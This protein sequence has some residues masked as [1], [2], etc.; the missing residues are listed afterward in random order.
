MS[1]RIPH[2]LLRAHR[3]FVSIPVRG[4]RSRCVSTRADRTGSQRLSQKHIYKSSI[5]WTTIAIYFAVGASTGVA[6]GLVQVINRASAHDRGRVEDIDVIEEHMA[7]QLP[8]GRPGTLTPDEEAR[9]RELWRLTLQVTGVIS[10]APSTRSNGDSP[11]P[12][13]SSSSSATPERKK[14]SRLSFMKKKKHD[15][16]ENHVSS[17]SVPASGWCRTHGAVV[18]ANAY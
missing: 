18:S 16:K 8:R 10:Q 3:S 5:N 4:T 13:H 11:E 17:T 15:D 1:R 2:L 9:L 12:S 14:K 6:I 7:A